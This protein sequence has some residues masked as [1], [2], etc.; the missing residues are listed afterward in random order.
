MHIKYGEH[1]VARVPDA[2]LPLSAQTA[3]FVNELASRTDLAAAVAPGFAAESGTALF[4][5]LAAA[6]EIDAQVMLPGLDPDLVDVDLHDDF[7]QLS[8]PLFIGSCAHE[9]GHAAWSRF[10]PAQLLPHMSR[11]HVDV[12]A[13]LEESR[14]ELLMARRS[15]SL[16]LCLRLTAL[17]LIAREVTIPKSAY[18]AAALAG[19]LLAR[20]DAGVLT[21]R[22]AA[23]FQ[24]MCVAVLGPQTL[25]DLQQVWQAFHSFDQHDPELAEEEAIA[26]LRALAQQWLDALPESDL[27]SE[28]S[29]EPYI[30]APDQGSGPQ[31]GSGDDWDRAFSE[32]IKEMAREALNEAEQDLGALSSEKRA[33]KQIAERVKHAAHRRETR[34]AV[35][36]ALTGS[37]N[38]ADADE[39]LFLPPRPP[40]PV[41]RAAATRLASLLERI[42]YRDRE[43]VRV[44]RMEPGGR[45]NGRA[46]MAAAAERAQGKMATTPMWN[47]KK[48]T[49]VDDA[50][51]TIG[52]MT[53]VSGSMGNAAGPMATCGFVLAHATERIGGKFAS[54]T[55]GS[56]ARVVVRPHERVRE[57]RGFHA[58]DGVESFELGF[59]VLDGL[60]ELLDSTGARLLV[61]ASDM[62]FV[63]PSEA[64]YWSEAS[65][66]CSAAGVSVMHLDF[67]GILEVPGSS[68]GSKSAEVVDVQGMPPVEVARLVGAR[69]ARLMR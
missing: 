38:D 44:R 32:E 17:E 69:A 54:V 4:S 61:I 58:M 36:A 48:R 22:D 50:S 37:D 19:L 28:A 53:D 47:A 41:E 1:E 12:L 43:V 23:P 66:M 35:E 59:K 64:A 65:R 49:P 46:A 27:D 56:T 16:V 29:S 45:L 13:T 8:H 55:F 63:R 39:D 21:D 10:V 42:S 60:L 11:R 6:I 20:R 67:T 25:H 14:V 2:W 26:R 7:W 3:S 30:Y 62:F 33:T 34:A 31:A 52:L 68:L 40:L 24:D 57:V 15:P 18:G 51:L 5:P 9:A